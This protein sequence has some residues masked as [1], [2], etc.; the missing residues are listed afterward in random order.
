MRK[1]VSGV[2]A[3]DPGWKRWMKDWEKTNLGS[4]ALKPSPAA[5]SCFNQWRVNR[6]LPF[7]LISHTNTHTARLLAPQGHTRCLRGNTH[8]CNGPKM[9]TW[10]YRISTGKPQLLDT[11]HASGVPGGGVG[12]GAVGSSSCSGW[13]N[14]AFIFRLAL[15]PSG[16]ESLL[17]EPLCQN[18]TGY[19]TRTLLDSYHLAGVWSLNEGR[20]AAKMTQHFLFHQSLHAE[21][22]KGRK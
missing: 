14:S 4:G 11:T 17:A 6:T 3:C 19:V 15:W 18:H 2:L 16:Y 22:D 20:V 8:S 10:P 13:R 1:C 5:V 9:V 21:T 12:H 7:L